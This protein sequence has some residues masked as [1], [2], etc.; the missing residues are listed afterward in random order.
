MKI[1]HSHRFKEVVS[2]EGNDNYRDDLSRSV[3]LCS[4]FCSVT[5]KLSESLGYEEF[6]AVALE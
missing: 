5:D 4:V 2:G 1:R 3:T 6:R